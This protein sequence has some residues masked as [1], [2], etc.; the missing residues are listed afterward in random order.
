MY[1]RKIEDFPTCESPERTSSLHITSTYKSKLSPPSGSAVFKKL[2][3]IHK[4]GDMKFFFIAFIPPSK[5]SLIKRK[6]IV[7]RKVDKIHQKPFYR[8]AHV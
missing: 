1:R 8:I 2:N 4:K 3:T 6:T 5:C 7:E